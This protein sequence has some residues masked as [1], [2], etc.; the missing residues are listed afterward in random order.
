MKRRIL[1]S[2]MALVLVFGLLPATAFAE[3]TPD[4][5]LEV[6]IAEAP[7]AEEG[8]T[9]AG[10]TIYVDAMSGNDVQ[11]GVGT[12]ADKAYKS[13]GEA[14]KAAESGDTIKLAEGNYSLYDVCGKNGASNSEK[15]TKNKDLTFVGQEEEVDKVNWYIGANPTPEGYKGEYDGDYCF[16]GA[17]TI[18]FRNLTL[19]AGSKNYLGFIRADKTIV[20]DCIINGKTFYWGYTSATFTN[21]TF[22]CPSGDYAIWTY[23]SPVMTFDRC[24]FNSSGKVINVYNENSAA[25]YTINFNNC[26]VNNTGFPVKQVLNINDSLVTGFTINITGDTVLKGYDKASIVDNKTC[27]RLFGFGG[28]ANTNNTGRTIV[29]FDGKTVWEDGEMVNAKAYHTNGVTVDGVTYDNGVAGA[30]DSLYAE[31]YKDNE[32]D[33][34]YGEWEKKPDGTKTRTVTKTCNYCGYQEKTTQN[35]EADPIEWDVSKSKTATKLDTS[36]WTSN[37]TLSLPSAEENLASDVVF[38]LD[39]SSSASTD[40][41]KKSLDLLGELKTAADDSGAAVNVCVVKFKRQAYKSDWFDLS[42]DFDAIQTAMGTKYSG[43]T[44]LHAG[45]LAGQEALEEHTHVAAGRKYLILVSDGSTYLYSKDGDWASDTPFTR[46]YYTKENYKGAAGGFWD[47]GMYEPNNYPEVNVVRPTAT[48][49][50]TAWQTY[51]ADVKARNE[52]VNSEGKTGDDYDYHCNYDLNFNQGIPSDDFKSQPC[53]PR[54]A[55]NR[56]MAFYYADQ[57]WQEIKNAGYNAYSI[58]TEDGMAG[59]GNADDSHCFMNYL[60]GGESLN[61][62]DIRQEILYAVGA[63]STVEDKMGDAFDFVPGSLKLTVGG[64]E[65]QSKAD[66]NVTYFGDDA[67]NLNEG[68][69]RFK[70]LYAPDADGFVWTINE[71]VSNFAPVQLTYTVK[72]TTPETD[73]GMY[74][75]EDL[76]GEKTLSD[77]EAEK[78][79]FTNA[80]AVLNAK[81][82]AGAPVKAQEFPKP[83]VS[84]TVHSFVPATTYYYFAV[85]KVDAQ[86]DHALS[87]ARF[88]LYLDGKQIAAATSDRSGL[89][90]FCVSESDYRKISANSSLYYQELTAPEGYLVNGDAVSIGKDNLTT[91]RAVAEKNAEMVRNYRNTV[92]AMLNGSDHFAYVVGYE[93]GCVRPNGLISRAETSSI[94]FRLLKDSVRDSKLLTTNTYADVPSDH[95]ANTAISTMTGLGIVQGYNSTTFDPSAP[96]TRAQFAAICA[97]FDTGKSSGTQTFTDIKGHWA[98]KYIER[99]AE[100]GW[101]KGFED[102]TFRPDTYITRAQAMT[103]INRVLNRI[104]E[105]ASD[106]LA[107]MNIWPDCN[108]GDWFYL[109]VQE[110]TNSHNYKHKAGNYETWT[111]MKQDPD[112]TRYEN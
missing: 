7:P 64:T 96:I 57:V 92:P 43:G 111:S 45:L 9:P 1:S 11:D 94:F 37:V 93:D 78:A 66:G 34:A 76:N 103:M 81:N 73:P 39:G 69:Y 31:G 85:E 40:V 59:A 58:A 35:A 32:F 88:G 110:A 105:D 52:T 13:I 5:E 17:K 15:Y 51:L 24:T 67:E 28:K 22:N 49:D 54:T 27:S 53:E 19:R 20:E 108:P 55:N 42:K 77:A 63:G 87:G 70:V 16:D 99:A 90:L 75:V 86:D 25:D 98:E 104:P 107:G 65:L 50:V 83:S 100:L 36:T 30:N 48:S 29:K 38:V 68:N 72:L 56:D 80:Y 106:L 14:V 2:L 112:W 71:N 89:V 95:W 44:N 74:G 8:E 18:T 41:V 61:F 3:E 101:I 10:N 62:S 12:T 23:C 82:S 47:N 84:Y 6:T 60:N 26:T 91:N 109:A 4:A 97:R 33:V 21:T 102:G 79:L 46:S